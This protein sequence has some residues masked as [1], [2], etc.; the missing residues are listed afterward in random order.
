[1]LIGYAIPL[2]VV[3]SFIGLLSFMVL[4]RKE[5]AQLLHKSTS[6]YSILALLAIL[7]FFVAF[8]LLYVHPVEQ[9]YFD[10]NIYQ[11]IAMNILAHG[12]ALWC[13]YGTGN[14]ANCYSNQ[15]Y[16]DPVGWCV[17][18]AMAFAAFG[19]GIGTAYGLELLVGALSI[20]AVF[21]LSSVLFE[22]KSI[23]VISALIFATM[24]LLYIWSRTQADIDLPF[25]MLAVFAFF[26]FTVF[27]RKKSFNALA[28][29]AFSLVLAA[30]M[31]IEAMLL[32]AVFALLL[33]LFGDLGVR[34]EIRKN[35]GA[36]RIALADN[37]KALLLLIAFIVLLTPE[38]YY[39]S[40]EAASPSYGQ[41]AG[42]PVLSLSNFGNNLGTNAYFVFG[43]L[44]N[45]NSPGSYPLVFSE[46]AMA[47]AIIGTLLFA[48]D[49][50]H[51]NRFGV[52][53]VLWLW[54]FAYF[55]FY[56]AFYA[57]AATY[58]VD[59]RFMLQLMPPLSVLGALAVFELGD[60]AW[61]ITQSG[62]GKSKA[63]GS[64]AFCLVCAA[65]VCAAV[66]YPF[67]AVAPVITMSPQEMPQQTVILKAVNFFYGNYNS[68]P[69]DC[70]VFSFTPDIWYEVNVS[71]AQIGD[72]ANPTPSE[73]A[74][75][76]AVMDYGYWCVVPPY[77]NT[78]CEMDRGEYRMSALATGSAGNG[79]NV[80]FYRILN[81]S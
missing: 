11:G 52:L 50:R 77:R 9:L 49:G 73:K 70:L 57:G 31:R 81:Y 76:C 54:F 43:A 68:V 55:V 48:A 38:L 40:L 72:L 27:S 22:R 63:A 24:P 41:P 60:W 45:M 12:N 8:S 2:A 59:S 19:T 75:G 4:G 29:F 16:H 15:V 14:L 62:A 6:R 30:Y 67:L 44:S 74:Y 37:T 34:D 56:T 25:M 42:Q 46:T 17:F 5:L 79:N 36:I 80:S 21:L 20:A 3:A 1:M 13:Q 71:S 65:V 47:L 10:E 66:L 33:V 39:I 64:A 78:T 32:V 53:A 18:I 58:G 61:A 35:I 7:A 23:A 28:M 69:K 26:F 51:R